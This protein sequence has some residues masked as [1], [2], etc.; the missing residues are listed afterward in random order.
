MENELLKKA[1]LAINNLLAE[2]FEASNS[3]FEDPRALLET[4]QNARKILVEIRRATP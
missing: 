4:A 2:I 3:H 1:E